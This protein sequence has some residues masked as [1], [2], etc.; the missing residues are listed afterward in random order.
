MIGLSA[1]PDRKDGLS[2]VFHWFLGPI[3]Y[4][5]T[6]EREQNILVKMVKC[7][8]VEPWYKEITNSRGK[9]NVPSMLTKLGEYPDRTKYIVAQITALADEG[10][11]VLVLSDRRAHVEEMTALL[12]DGGV[13][14][15]TMM[16]ATKKKTKRSVN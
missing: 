2:K 12:R 13:D 6:I 14:A 15:G 3:R 9:A 8:G 4:A 11:Q 5:K 10:R 7:N 1:T 16:G